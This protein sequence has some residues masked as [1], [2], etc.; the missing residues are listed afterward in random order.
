[1]NPETEEDDWIDATRIHTMCA[2]YA[3]AEF[4]S[5]ALRLATAFFATIAET[6]D[7]LLWTRS[8]ALH[9]RAQKK[10]VKYS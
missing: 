4:K 9:A 3:K 5:V 7:P 6:V 2:S 10:I 1:M 8:P